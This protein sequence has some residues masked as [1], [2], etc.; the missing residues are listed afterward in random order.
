MTTKHP[1]VKD[2]DGSGGFTYRSMHARRN[3]KARGT[4]CHYSA[5]LGRRS[6]QAATRAGIIAEIDA[7]W[8]AER[9]GWIAVRRGP[10]YCAPR[11]GMKCTHAAFI[12]AGKR[13]A[14][15]C[16][17]LGEGWTPRVWE[18]C[19]WHYSAENGVASMHEYLDRGAETTY[20]LFF[21]TATQIVIQGTDPR[22]MVLQAVEDAGKHAA[23]MVADAM[24]ITPRA[25]QAA[26][27]EP[28]A[29][30]GR[31]AAA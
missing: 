2:A 30:K 17:L 23:A 1:I 11:C 28:V 27:D 26:N 10:I 9:V 18:N 7:Y 16:K 14:A 20:S 19:G 13:A 22:L 5:F 4:D 25:T 15:L 3:A 24:Q 6:L 21:N 31:R 29:R 12:K 8:E